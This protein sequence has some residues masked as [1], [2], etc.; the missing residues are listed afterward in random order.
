M[1]APVC[2]RSLSELRISARTK[3]NDSTTL[4]WLGLVK[5]V[6]LSKDSCWL[7]SANGPEP[8]RGQM[9]ATDCCHALD[10]Q[11]QQQQQQ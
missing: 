4:S 3:L 1:Y 11:Q 2:H 5:Q 7:A 9:G 8:G 10:Q 6:L